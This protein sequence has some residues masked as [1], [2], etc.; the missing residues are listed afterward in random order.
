[1]RYFLE[2][3]KVFHLEMMLQKLE[4]KFEGHSIP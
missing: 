3:V 4:G 1:M 2:P